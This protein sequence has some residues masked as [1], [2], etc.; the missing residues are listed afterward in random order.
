VAIEWLLVY[1][2][3]IF[4]YL[5]IQA[6]TKSQSKVKKTICIFAYLGAFERQLNHKKI[7]EDTI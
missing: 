5:R 3:C 7:T 4:A 2:I 1:P 6:P